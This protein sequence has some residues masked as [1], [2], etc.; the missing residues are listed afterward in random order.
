MGLVCWVSVGLVYIGVRREYADNHEN[1]CY[2]YCQVLP[3][4]Q[5]AW[6][7]AMLHSIISVWAVEGHQLHIYSNM[8][9]TVKNLVIPAIIDKTWKQV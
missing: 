5:Q 3:L 9:L 8:V 4:E 6:W 1:K 7:S 2:Y